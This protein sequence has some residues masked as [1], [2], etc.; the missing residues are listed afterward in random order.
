MYNTD[1][2]LTNFKEADKTIL[3]T[4]DVEFYSKYD[5]IPDEFN[6]AYNLVY[7]SYD[8]RNKKKLISKVKN[9]YLCG[10]CWAISCA[11]A[12]SDAY[13]IRGLVN[14]PPNISY[15]YALSRYP[16][17]KC[18]GG[19]SRILLEDIKNGDGIASDFCVDESWCL[20]DKQCVTADSSKHLS[21]TNQEY[22]SSL[23]PPKG[24]YNGNKRHYVY[25]VEDVYSLAVSD[26]SK[27]L[28]TQNKIKQHI[29]IRGPVVGGFLILDNFPDGK[30]P[31]GIY[32][33][34]VPFSKDDNYVISYEKDKILGSHSVVI[35]GWGIAKNVVYNNIK[36]N[37]PYWYCRNSWGENW[38]DA[39]HFK[40]AMYP[41]NRVC[42]FAKKIRILHNGIIK[43]VGGSTGFLVSKS[44][45][46]RK[47]RWN[48]TIFEK[49]KSNPLLYQVDENL[50]YDGN[51]DNSNRVEKQLL[52]ISVAVLALLLWLPG[53]L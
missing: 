17:Q 20:N 29:M 22:L 5:K 39:G 46:L 51:K 15:T 28:E 7:D 41:Y 8:E 44:P 34:N 6:W 30:F 32:I 50:I 45:I 33:E 37:I 13:V 11:T 21:N 2:D 47:I 48:K 19:S 42:Q 26:S 25:C 1:I 31:R 10:C 4:I 24:C 16:Q 3:N 14:W 40:I 27:I 18:S 35:V 43:E 53:R 36:T 38:A 52:L 23:I 12:I 49:Y 9:Q